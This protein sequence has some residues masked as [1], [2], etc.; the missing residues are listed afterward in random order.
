M[1]KLLKGDLLLLC[2][3]GGG[4]VPAA[5]MLLPRAGWAW[6]LLHAE[7]PLGVRGGG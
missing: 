5:H 2:Q 4:G 6:S 7:R 1:E 3:V